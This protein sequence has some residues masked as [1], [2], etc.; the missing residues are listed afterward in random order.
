MRRLGAFAVLVLGAALFVSSAFAAPVNIT[1]P[2]TDNGALKVEELQQALDANLTLSNLIQCDGVSKPYLAVGSA[3]SCPPQDTHRM[4]LGMLLIKAW[5]PNTGGSAADTTTIVR[6][7]IQIRTH[8]EGQVDSSSV[9][10]VYLY[11]KSEQGTSVA[12]ASQVDTTVSGHIINAPGGYPAAKFSTASGVPV[13][14]WNAFSGEY[15]VTISSNRNAHGSTVSANQAGYYFP[16][17]IAIPLTSLFGRELYSPS[18]S[19]R[20]RVLSS[21]LGSTGSVSITMHLIGTPL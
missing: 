14:S 17:G 16:N 12:A 21:T 19:I 18:T 1:A 9:F 6:I 11:G 7:A 8:L 10:P 2:L 20:A 15:V 4:R 3:D 13:P 5:V